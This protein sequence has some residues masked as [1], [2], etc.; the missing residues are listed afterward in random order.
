MQSINPK[1]SMG[2]LQLSEGEKKFQLT[3]YA[4]SEQ[5]RH[6]V[7]HYWFIS[8]ALEGQA[9]YSQD[10]VPNPCVNMVIEEHQSGIYGAASRR[11]TKQIE[12]NGHVFGV[13]FQPGGFYPFIHSPLA[14][15]T[16]QSLTL[17]AVF[18]D[19]A[20]K[21]V[22]QMVNEHEPARMIALTEALL[23]KQLPEEDPSVNLINEII[24]RI[25]EDRSLTKVEQLCGIFDMNIRKLQRLFNQYVG[26]SPKW[27]I[28]LYRL[29]NAA[30]TMDMASQPDLLK[31]TADL[32][33]YDQSHFI[34]DFKSIIGKTPEEYAK[35]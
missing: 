1:P 30:E 27:V 5:L 31:L 29:Q 24:N 12:G 23:L 7:K 18:G 2:I 28:K 21:Y 25:N 19:E 3:R 6:L 20:I 32:G 14:E 16:D 15:L 9:P 22:H 4:P 8:W 13:K 11:Y 33:Y 17:A 26:I 35:A 10:V 34:K